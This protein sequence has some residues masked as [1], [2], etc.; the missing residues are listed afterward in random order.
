MKKYNYSIDL[1]RFALILYI[2]LYHYTAGYNANAEI[3]PI[4]FPHSFSHGGPVGTTLFFILA[5]YFMGS[6][7]LSGKFNKIKEYFI[8]CLKRYWRFWPAYAFAVLIIFLWMLVLPVP[9]KQVGFGKFIVNFVF[10]IHPGRYV[11]GAHWF[12]ATL[13]EI[14]FFTALIKFAPPSC[15]IKGV[16]N[17]L[18]E[19]LVVLLF[20]V[21]G[22]WA[23]QMTYEPTFKYIFVNSEAKL[24][25]GVIIYMVQKD[26]SKFLKT[27]FILSSFLM[28]CVM[29]QFWYTFTPL[30]IVMLLLFFIPFSV[31]PKIGVVAG[32]LGGISFTWYLVHQNIGYS[33]MYHYCPTGEVG[34]LWLAMPLVVTSIIAICIQWPSKI[35]GELIKFKEK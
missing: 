1:F 28:V 8:F 23:S 5:G 3:N 19:L 32:F 31:S 15:H 30:Y 25:M 12:L 26:N 33:L 34:F 17:N 4:Y 14:Q 16:N 27:I 24:L 35:F 18:R 11:D 9:G 22:I 2:I 29:R 10:I 13:L 20:S 21:F 6:S 7:L